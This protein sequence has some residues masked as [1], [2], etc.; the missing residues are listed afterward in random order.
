[1]PYYEHR[2]REQNNGRFWTENDE[3]TKLCAET[4]NKC[5]IRPNYITHTHGTFHTDHK[6]MATS[7]CYQKVWSQIQQRPQY[8][9]NWYCSS[10]AKTGRKKAQ[11]EIKQS[12]VQGMCSKQRDSLSIRLL[13][14]AFII[15]HLMMCGPKGE[16]IAVF[17][18]FICRPP[19]PCTHTYFLSTKPACF[20]LT[21]SSYESQ[22]AMCHIFSEACQRM[23]SRQ[24]GRG[25]F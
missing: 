14:P 15:L 1:M 16:M 24:G 6:V 5:D 10:V 11:N 17:H 4:S 12:Q 9:L 20:E 13:I 3:P 18:F 25:G 8:C 21:R 22:K 23:E 19:P 2:T 7:K